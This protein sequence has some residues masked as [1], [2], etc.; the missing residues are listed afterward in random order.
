LEASATEAGDHAVLVWLR[1]RL[2]G[3]DPYLPLGDMEPPY[4]LFVALAQ[5]LSAD[6][7]LRQQ[8]DRCLAILLDE[9]WQ[10][11]PSY[12]AELLFL[13]KCI[14]PATCL[15][16]LR[17][18]A[19]KQPFSRADYEERRDLLWLSAAAA[20]ADETLRPVWLDILARQTDKVHV[21]VAYLAVARDPELAL[22]FLPALFHALSDDERSVLIE[23]ALK[24][25]HERFA[26]PVRFLARVTHHLLRYRRHRGLVELVAACMQ[27]LG[28]PLPREV[29][30][31]PESPQ[32]TPP[33]PAC[34]ARY[35]AFAAQPARKAR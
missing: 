25:A 2:S 15:P 7:P 11:P 24:D 8:L 6:R 33:R 28:V 34:G 26:D 10:T 5:R 4:S 1:Q 14:C 23:E 13:I 21:P 29:L 17:Q 18:V 12:L 3:R 27:T 19:M 16:R 32:P 22:V 35:A 31:G 30:D 9:A 20:Y